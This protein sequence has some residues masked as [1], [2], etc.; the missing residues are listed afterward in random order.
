MVIQTQNYIIKTINYKFYYG[1]CQTHDMLEQ[2]VNEQMRESHSKW[3]NEASKNITPPMLLMP[4]ME[5]DTPNWHKDPRKKKQKKMNHGIPNE[6][7][8]DDLM[9]D[10]WDSKEHHTSITLNPL[11]NLNNNPKKPT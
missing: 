5:L 11:P 10:H 7:A 3:A 8:G 6:N 9:V 1:S 4:T 2:V